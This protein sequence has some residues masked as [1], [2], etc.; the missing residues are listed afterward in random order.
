MR[1]RSL[2]RLLRWSTTLTLSATTAG[3]ML[4]AAAPA[5]SAIDV[6]L[7]LNYTCPF[8]LLGDQPV[9]VTVAAQIPD[10]LVTGHA[11]SIP[12]SADVTVPA[13][14]TKGLAFMN[15]SA[16]SG[17][18]RASATLSDGSLTLPLSLPLQIPATPVPG[19][20]SFVVHASGRS[21][22][23]TLPSG[24]AK[25]DVGSFISALTPVQTLN[26][27]TLPTAVGT[28]HSRCT[29]DP[30]QNTTLATFNVAPPPIAGDYA[31][32]GSAHFGA[33]GVEA[34]VGPGT[35]SGSF[36]GALTT[37]TGDLS[38]P[39]TTVSYTLLGFLPGTATFRM[40]EA[41]KTTGTVA[42]GVLAL[43]SP[44]TVGIT[45]AALLGMPL[46]QS[47]ATCQTTTPVDLALT[48]GT[49]FQ[50]ASPVTMTGT[51]S[52]PAFRGCGMADG[53][54]GSWFSGGTDTISE[55]LNPR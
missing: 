14:S 7:A 22:A 10:A 27:T 4:F 6:S 2:R 32:V 35:L 51:F 31:V 23:I 43:D 33:A 39:P 49:G 17:T 15:T 12:F 50:P 55:E 48:S 28:F 19:S 41:D 36:D 30:G 24:A 18:A 29:A 46:V 53:L 26:G 45:D 20:G 13:S 11:A 16:I 1:I 34:K 25:I 9:Q 44:I 52:L 38:L 5:A 54:L 40:N 47:S 37:F 3:E 21:P 8:P 42:D